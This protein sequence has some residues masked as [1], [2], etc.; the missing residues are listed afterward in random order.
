[1][2][3]EIG[4]RHARDS[5]RLLQQAHYELHKKGDR[6]QASGKAAGA[7]A[8]AVKAVAFDRHWRHSSHNLR[9]RIVNLLAAEFNQPELITLQ[10][11]ADQL[12]DNFYE[13]RLYEWELTTYLAR[14]AAGMELLWAVRA[15]ESNHPVQSHS[16]AAGRAVRARESNPDFAPT[17][18]QQQIIARL[19][20]TEAEAA[21]IPLIDYPPELPPFVA[22]EE[23]D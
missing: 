19:L 13:D 4:D 2:P 14:I 1:M 20:L 15:R 23:D 12:H 9:R 3:T 22:P 11:D 6:L 7:V 18:E 10:G 17:P 5:L 8:H 21:A 16:A